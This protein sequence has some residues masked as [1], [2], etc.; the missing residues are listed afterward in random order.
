[1]V[2]LPAPD[3]WVLFDVRCVPSTAGTSATPVIVASLWLWM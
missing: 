3:S 2:P 1:M